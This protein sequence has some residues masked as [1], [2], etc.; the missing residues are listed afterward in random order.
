MRKSQF[1]KLIKCLVREVVS[2]LDMTSPSDADAAL[3]AANVAASPTASADAATKAKMQRDVRKNS[4]LKLRAIQKSEKLE[5]DA[6]KAEDKQ[7]K[8][9]Q[10]AY[11]KQQSDL[12][13]EL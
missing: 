5:K 7:W 12:K 11:R 6:H 13:R 8:I 1:N 9:K 3:A 2:S 4:Q 10:K